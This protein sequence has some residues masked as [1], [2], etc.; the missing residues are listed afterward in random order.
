MGFHST[1]QTVRSRIITIDGPAGVGKTTAAKNLSIRIGF[2][3]LDTGALYRAIALH[4]LR[5]GLSQDVVAV[6]L[7]H[8]APLDLRIEA[9][10]GGMRLYLNGEDITFRIRDEEISDAASKFSALAQV[11][12]FLLPL[13]RDIARRQDTVAEGRDMGTVVF[14]EADLKFFLT[15]DLQERARRRWMELMSRGSNVL[16]QDVE[17]DI[18]SRD[19]RDAGRLNAPL[20]RPGDAICIDT[21]DL[22]ADEVVEQLLLHVTERQIARR[23]SS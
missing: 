17:T 23:Y 3:F 6:P 21:T 10:I 18:R 14:P 20:M 4:L 11:R 22:S 9:N 12:R 19:E 5:H 2:L 13:Q 16:Q 8:L 7:E 1:T 15:A